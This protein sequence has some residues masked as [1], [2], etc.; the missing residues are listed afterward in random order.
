MSKT[1]IKTEHLG[2]SYL[3]TNRG[4]ASYHSIREEIGLSI[5]NLFSAIKN[6]GSKN[7]KN[8][9]TV[10]H[11]LKSISFEIKKGEIVGIIGRNGAGKS[12]LLKLLGRITQPSSGS[13]K[14]KGRVASLLEVGTGFHPELTG[15]EN[16]FLSGAILGMK[17]SE[18][19]KYF[20]EIV[21]FAGVE[22]FLDTPVKRYSS[23]MFVRL[24]FAIAAH[25]QA[26]I[27]LV[28]EVLAVGD[29]AFQKKCLGKIGEVAKGGRTVL[30]VSHN[31]GAIEQLCDSAIVLEQG[32]LFYQGAIDQALHSYR[33]LNK[34]HGAERIFE[35]TDR[36]IKKIVL[37]TEGEKTTSISRGAQLSIEVAFQVER[38]IESPVLG[39]VI[40]DS[41]NV[42][43]I[44][45]NNRHYGTS[46]ENVR[47]AAGLFSIAI[48][49]LPLV[50][51]EYTID[52]YLGDIHGDFETLENAISFFVEGTKESLISSKIDKRLNRI[53]ITDMN[54]EIKEY[55]N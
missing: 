12:T 20:E 6:I 22:Q 35:A 7:S 33:L 53:L 30:F 54:W 8:D 41:Y 36:A 52:L 13:I 49:A 16:I 39:I 21:E 10:F 15:R 34:E 18:V 38:T 24:G 23:G 1:V 28:D 27:L 32:E 55:E 44:G 14:I 45:V 40:R 4:G 48:P 47:L 11:A 37:Y 46:F 50:P 17:R 3:I 25:L 2:K 43:V 5:Q 29:L 19:K 51:G 26:E 9:Q 42:P 31:L